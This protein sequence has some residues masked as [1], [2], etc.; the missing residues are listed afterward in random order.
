MTSLAL[1]II[2]ATVGGLLAGH[3]AQKLFGFFGGYG[4]EGTA[5]WLESLNL[6]PGKQWAVM[7]GMSEF[8]GGMLTAIG[9]LN[10]IGPIMAMGAMVMATLKVHLGKPVWTSAGGA[11]LPI[12]NMA[13]LLALF[14]AGPGKLSFDSLLGIR[15]PRWFSVAA[16][17]GTVAATYAVAT[18]SGMGD[19]LEQE[20]EDEVEAG[21]EIQA[22]GSSRLGGEADTTA[23]PGIESWGSPDAAEPAVEN[24]AIAAMT[25]EEA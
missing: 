22:Q 15:V 25:R 19:E 7:A 24:P 10:P 12:T 20:D 13:A 6:R 14:L 21:G 1:L 11:E 17:I 3:G 5:G 16:L 2:R 8:L 4:V 9:A 18:Q 23:R